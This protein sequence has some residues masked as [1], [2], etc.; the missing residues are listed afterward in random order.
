MKLRYPLSLL[1][2]ALLMAVVAGCNR[3][4]YRIDG[5]TSQPAQLP[6]LDAEA[7]T[8]SARARPRP[9]LRALPADVLGV[10]AVRVVVV[11][12]RQSSEPGLRE[13]LLA[14]GDGRRVGV[15]YTPPGG[16]TLPVSTDD[17]LNVQFQPPDSE[18]SFRGPALILREVD[19]QL[20]A[21]LAAGGGLPPGILGGEVELSASG[22]LVYADA[23][24]LPSLC[25]VATLH[26]R[27]RVR[28]N[29]SFRYLP[30]GTE[31]RLLL[32]GAPYRIIT[33]DVSRPS[34]A[35]C[36]DEV[37]PELSF[38]VLAL[39]DDGGRARRDGAVQAEP[40]TPLS[41]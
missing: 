1:A 16:Y 37:A 8:V 29:E 36:G 34:D 11:A 33:L 20:I 23:R 18:A 7:D 26:Y 38:A 12:H 32:G 9:V 13:L 39:P 3:R 35:R 2:L 27:L 6:L 5:G 25:T 19:G 41:P 15:L 10:E 28:E 14:R 24:Q 30:P 22:R 4:G 31:G 40:S 17:V 21:A